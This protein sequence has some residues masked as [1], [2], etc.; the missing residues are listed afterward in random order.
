MIM[1]QKRKI[2]FQI[3]LDHGINGWFQ[4]S[5]ENWEENT[6]TVFDKFLSNDKIYIDIGAWIGPIV[7]YACQKSSKVICF[8]PDPIA[9]KI[10]TDNISINNFKN[11]ISYN[12][13]ISDK[14]GTAILNSNYTNFAGSVS[15]LLSVE[16]GTVISGQTCE[17]KTVIL[18]NVL[19]E[20]NIDPRSI[21]LIKIDIEGG[22]KFVVPQII[23]YLEKTKIPLYISIHWC[24]LYEKDAINIIELLWKIYHNVYDNGK[25][26]VMEEII[27]NYRTTKL[28][29]TDLLFTD[30]TW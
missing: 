26:T 17:V 24:F 28:Q 3:S 12:Y 14:E 27:N 18:E 22:E 16:T 21:S 15:T 30:S 9:Q 13:A 1:I 11:I 25:K 5:Y 2:N 4:N 8:E 10:L 23:N 19:S 29:T 7:L 20:L 6:F